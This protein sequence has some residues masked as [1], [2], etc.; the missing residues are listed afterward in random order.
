M[1]YLS[2]GA[3]FRSENSWLDEW[4]LYHRAIGVEHFYLFNDD[5]NTRV[6]DKILQPYVDAGFVD[7]VH[8]K[9]IDGLNHARNYWR[10]PEIYRIL[11]RDAIDETEWLAL[12]DL[13]E[14]LLPKT[15]DDIRCFLERYDAHSGFAMNWHLFGSNGYIKRPFTQI[16]HLLRRANTNW[17]RNQFIKSIIK[18]RW[19]DQSRIVDVHYFPTFRGNTVNE[20]EETVWSMCHEISTKTICLNH[21][22]LRSWQDFWEIKATRARSKD[23]SVCDENFFRF[24]DRNECFDDEISRRFGHVLT[25]QK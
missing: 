13:D 21:Y 4:I 7:H 11:V 20:N 3:V 19:V 10:Q 22:T 12:I 23:S 25:S 9:D 16:N 1:K 14:F 5:E 17:K 24:H 6:S 18:P 2:I 8:I 15:C